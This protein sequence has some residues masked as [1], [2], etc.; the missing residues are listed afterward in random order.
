MSAG[1]MAVAGVD[2]ENP[3]AAGVERRPVPPNIGIDDAGVLGRPDHLQKGLLT[4][5]LIDQFARAVLRDPIEHDEECHRLEVPAPALRKHVLDEADG[6][7]L[8]VRHGTDDAQVD[9]IR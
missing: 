9:I 5:M 7:G 3:V 4:G 1:L 6:I 8:F 2:L